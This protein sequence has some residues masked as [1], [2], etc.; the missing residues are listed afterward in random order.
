VDLYSLTLKRKKWTW[1]IGGKEKSGEVDVEVDCSKRKGKGGLNVK[2]GKERIHF[3]KIGGKKKKG[4]KSSFF[5]SKRKVKDKGGIDVKIGGSGSGKVKEPKIK[6]EVEVKVKGPKVGG[7]VDV[8]I[9]GK[10]P[11]GGT[12]I[13][14]E[15]KWKDQKSKKTLKCC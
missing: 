6:G 13:D 5:S 2:D 11:K 8:D 9:G 10:G 7:E 3:S 15:E 12:E 1:C 4:S 14:M